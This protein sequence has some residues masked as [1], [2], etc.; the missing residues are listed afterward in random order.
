[1][2]VIAI[3]L[4]VFLF[5][6]CTNR[7]KG[8]PLEKGTPN[9]TL[10]EKLAVKVPE[11]D[12]EQNKVLATTTTF[13]L[14]VGDVVDKFRSRFG[15]QAETLDKQ[16]PERLKS[17]V[18]EL[19]EGVAMTKVALNRAKE[20]NI[21]ISDQEV[22]SLLQKQFKQAGGEENFINMIARNGITLDIV[23]QEMKDN[24]TIKL[25]IDKMKEK[26]VAVS[27]EEVDEALKSDKTATVRHILL[28][29]THKS[30]SSKKEVYT[31][32]QEIL[33]RAKAGE[34]FAELAKQYT[35]DPGSKDNGGLYEDF[36]RGKMV[37]PFEDAA[38]SVP[39]GEIS[40][41][42]ETDYGYHILKIEDRKKE[43]RP[44][45]VVK[46]ELLQNK[47]KNIVKTIYERIKAESELTIV[48]L[49]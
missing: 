10:A 16:S 12:P 38:F 47:S 36:P 7:E 8:M 14:T 49:P 40:D 35:E 11:L 24:E 26:E 27:E 29:T 45:D 28:T 25:F 19:A 34:D 23:R 32:M 18:K 17:I 13:E 31:K 6:G 4:I 43:D 2:K 15:K 41:I 30:D 21:S 48:D 44:R 1:M 42:V 33:K 20:E 5:A 22:D 39:V 9:Y 3:L 46:A 37:K